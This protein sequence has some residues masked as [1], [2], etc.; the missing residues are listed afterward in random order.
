MWKD[1]VNAPHDESE[2]YTYSMHYVSIILIY[3]L[4]III[5]NNMI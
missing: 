2:G 3:C 1:Y 4:F 5:K